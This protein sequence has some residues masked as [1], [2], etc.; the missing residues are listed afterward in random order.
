M[1]EYLVLLLIVDA[2]ALKGPGSMKRMQQLL[3]TTVDN[4]KQDM[5]NKAKLE[6]L[7]SSV[8]ISQALKGQYTQK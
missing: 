3:I 8:L 4:I 1:N 5:F 2:L 6:V 7:Q